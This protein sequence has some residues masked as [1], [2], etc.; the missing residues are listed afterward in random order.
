MQ[1]KKVQKSKNTMEVGGG[2]R[3]PGI[4]R[5]FV[6]LLENHP[7]IAL[8]QYLL[9]FL[10]SIPSYVFYIYT[11]TSSTFDMQGQYCAMQCSSDLYTI[12]KDG[13]PIRC[14]PRN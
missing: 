2:S 6:C 11:V 1:R 13:Q 4:T 8:N 9:I 5:N 12:R 14:W 3:T 10:S 7:K